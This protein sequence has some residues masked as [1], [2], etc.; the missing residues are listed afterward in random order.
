MNTI[1]S[2]TFL[3]TVCAVLVS[4]ATAGAAAINVP[5]TS[6]PWLA[7]MPNGTQSNLNT[8][9]PPDVAPT[10]SPVLVA[11]L[12]VEPGGL[13]T[14]SASGQVGHPGDVAGPDGALNALTAHLVGAEHGMSDILAPIDSLLGVFLGPGQPDGNPA[15]ASLDFSTA[16]SRDYLSLAPALQQVFYMGDGLN[17]GNAAQSIVV[18]VGATR[19]YLGVMDG[20]G[21]ANNTGGFNVTL[22]SN[23]VP[24]SSSPLFLT[25]AVLIG[26]TWLRRRQVSN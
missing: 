1:N 6:N 2:R 20:F 14:W 4:A 7:G 15:P 25:G 5:G 16:A 18:P 22:A 10:H 23:C 3:L 13:I 24:D 21:W 26:M 12:C 17:S 9:E 8:P 11:N 19:L